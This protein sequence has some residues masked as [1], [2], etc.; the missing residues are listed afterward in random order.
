MVQPFCTW[1]VGN[2]KFCVDLVVFVDVSFNCMSSFISVFISRRGNHLA[3]RSGAERRRGALCLLVSVTV[4]CLEG[5]GQSGH[6]SRRTK[7]R[8][9]AVLIADPA[10]ASQ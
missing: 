2:V 6:L 9:K 7:A 4:S 10:R 8:D 3:L 1:L 5:G